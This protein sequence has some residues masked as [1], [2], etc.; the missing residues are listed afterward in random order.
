[1][2]SWFT[3]ADIIKSTAMMITAMSVAGARA[4]IAVKL[5][6]T[7]V[8]RKVILLIRAN[9]DFIAPMLG[10]T[11]GSFFHNAGFPDVIK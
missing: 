6:G 5:R 1:M 2:G 9:D 10:N 3:G 4:R 8:S 7:G 11:A